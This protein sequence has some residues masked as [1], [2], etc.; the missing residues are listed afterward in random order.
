MVE[1]E[2]MG[3]TKDAVVFGIFEQVFY[4]TACKVRYLASPNAVFHFD[5]SVVRGL[6]GERA[7]VGLSTS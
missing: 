5:V 4:Q 6:A 2:P 1:D 7:L 3:M